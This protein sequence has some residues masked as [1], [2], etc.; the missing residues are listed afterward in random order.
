VSQNPRMQDPTAVV[1]V[2]AGYTGGRL[3]QR[4][5]AAGRQVWL[6]RTTA[7]AATAQATALGPTVRGVGLRLVLPMTPSDLA[8]LEALPANAT[9]VLLAPPS[10]GPDAGRA[11]AALLA[12]A[13]RPRRVVY[14]SSTGVYGP[15]AGAWVDEA[16]APAPASASGRARL[17]AEAAVQAQGAPWCVLRPAGIYGPGRGLVARLR[18]GTMRVVGDGTTMVSRVHVDDLVT[19]IE[20]AI[21]V[22]AAVGRVINVADDEPSASGALADELAARLG[23]PAPPRVPRDDVPPEVA[24]MLTADR[25]I[26]NAALRGVLGVTLRYPTWREG[27]AAELSD[28]GVA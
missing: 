11:E 6:T 20:R 5:V 8:A 28:V 1:I 25:R 9:W 17:A 2:G 24:A 23:L 7:A 18:A 26:A 15:A 19:A 27:L 4:L 14:V 10:I 13:A 22:D 3:A 21:E 12:R 16:T